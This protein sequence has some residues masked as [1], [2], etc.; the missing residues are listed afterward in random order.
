MQAMQQIEI[1]QAIGYRATP[2]RGRDAMSTDE[3]AGVIAVGR[4]RGAA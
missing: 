3:A 2:R 1:P 4:Q